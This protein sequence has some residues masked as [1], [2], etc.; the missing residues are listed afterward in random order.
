MRVCRL[1]LQWK[2]LSF[3]W[4]DTDA[5]K[6]STAEKKFNLASLP[7]TAAAIENH[8]LCVYL[9]VQTWQ[10]KDLNPIQCSWRHS[11]NGLVLTGTNAPPAPPNILKMI[12]CSYKNAIQQLVVVE[13]WEYFA[14]TFLSARVSVWIVRGL[15]MK[16][17]TCFDFLTINS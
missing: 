13:K 8:S 16:T 3:W 4:T 6:K 15:R 1:E 7:P 12:F 11:V 10:N 9:Q 14:T 2:C 17:K 5:L